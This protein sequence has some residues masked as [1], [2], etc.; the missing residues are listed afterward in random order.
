MSLNVRSADDRRLPRPARFYT[1]PTFRFRNGAAYRVATHTPGISALQLQRQLG[2]GGYQHAWHVLPRL[3]KGMVHDVRSRLSRLV[4]ADE[5]FIGGPRKG[6]KGRGVVASHYKSLGV[7]AVE[8]LAYNATG[9][10][11]NA[12]ADCGLL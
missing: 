7:G 3:R 4:E 11:K 9:N 5:T 10:A 12:L 1:A 8:V 6:K 2:I